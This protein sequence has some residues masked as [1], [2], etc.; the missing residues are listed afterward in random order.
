MT[1]FSKA[2]E[3]RVLGLLCFPIVCG[4]LFAG[5][6]PFHHPPNDVSWLVGR[7]GVRVGRYG[8]L[9]SAGTFGP[10]PSSE[11][12]S[13]TIEIWAQPRTIEDSGT[14]LA[15]Y[16]SE[17]RRRFS[18]R[19]YD[20]LELRDEFLGARLLRGSR[21]Y[22]ENVFR[23]EVPAFITITAGAGGTAVYRDGTLVKNTSLRLPAGVLQG[24]LVLCTSPI[25]ND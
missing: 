17:S 6:S 11:G 18:V 1:K 5:L 13:F 25:D 15:F 12:S 19:Q 4:M 23:K 21:T 24:H 8:T 16:Q 9:K 14:L 3:S 2:A 10:S 7:D 20:G 22:V